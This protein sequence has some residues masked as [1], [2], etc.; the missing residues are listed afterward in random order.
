MSW[1]LDFP[2]PAP[3]MNSNQR[4][5]RRGQTATRQAWREAAHIWAIKA[6]LP[7]GLDHIHITATP[8][9]TDVR[10]RDVHNLMPTLKAVVDGLVDYGLI[11]DDDDAHLIGPDLRSSYGALGSKPYGRL[12]LE[13]QELP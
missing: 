2:A 9:L 11:P 1:T 4:R 6:K 10:K 8:M 3:W 7:K 5:D 12:V 13:I